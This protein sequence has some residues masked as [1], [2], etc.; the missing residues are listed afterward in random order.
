[1][2][3]WMRE[4]ERAVLLVRFVEEI[5]DDDDKDAREM[6]K[7][8]TKINERNF[9]DPIEVARDVPSMKVEM[10]IDE[11]SRFQHPT[12]IYQTVQP[13]KGSP[14][15]GLIQSVAT[16]IQTQIPGSMPSYPDVTRSRESSSTRRTPSAIPEHTPDTA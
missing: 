13:K 8:N 3:P 4:F 2:F 1:M 11:D 9:N 7:Y 6:I 10:A 5:D 12:A 14:T 16:R 15:P